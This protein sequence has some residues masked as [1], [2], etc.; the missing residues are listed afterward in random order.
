MRKRDVFCRYAS[1]GLAIPAFISVLMYML[2]ALSGAVEC[3][4]INP[5]EANWK[6]TNFKIFLGIFL[7]LLNGGNQLLIANSIIYQNSGAICFKQATLSLQ[8]WFHTTKCSP[9]CAKQSLGPKFL[10]CSILWRNFGG[11]H[12]IQSEVVSRFQWM[13][14]CFSIVYSSYTICE[15]TVSLFTCSLLD[16]DFYQN[17]FCIHR[18]TQLLLF[19][20]YNLTT[21][22]YL[23]ALSGTYWGDALVTK[24]CEVTAIFNHS[25]LSI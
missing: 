22:M 24:I 3:L 17:F 7:D 14:S 13:K 9:I 25:C 19:W 16:T 10:L 8:L 15:R 23:V 21:Y 11:H 18:G 5:C 6:S 4:L 1:L 12:L 20:T 2:C